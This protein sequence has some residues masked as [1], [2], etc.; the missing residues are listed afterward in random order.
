MDTIA[1][2][3]ETS[4]ITGKKEFPIIA[5]ISEKIIDLILDKKTIST[6]LN[7]TLKISTIHQWIKNIKILE[8]WREV[9]QQ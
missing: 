1:K 3:F 6:E 9:R 2:Y 4:T 7:K 8:V 5:P